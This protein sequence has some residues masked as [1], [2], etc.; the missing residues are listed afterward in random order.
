MRVDFLP[1]FGVFDVNL[2][3]RCA[4]VARDTGMVPDSDVPI[5]CI[6]GTDFLIQFGLEVARDFLPLR[7]GNLPNWGREVFFWVDVENLGEFLYLRAVRVFSEDELL[8]LV[9]HFLGNRRLLDVEPICTTNC[10]RHL[11]SDLKGFNRARTTN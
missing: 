6:L 10:A 1:V 8:Q 4:L 3:G 9:Y 2:E 11:R 7:F 5:W